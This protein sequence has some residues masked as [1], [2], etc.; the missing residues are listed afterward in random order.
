MAT[1]QLIDKSIVFNP[2]CGTVTILQDR[3]FTDDQGN[4]LAKR[5]NIANSLTKGQLDK[6]DRFAK[7]KPLVIQFWELL[8]AENPQPAN[9][10]FKITKYTKN[11]GILG[12]LNGNGSTYIYADFASGEL[13]NGDSVTITGS[14]EPG[15]NET[16]IIDKTHSGYGR[17][18]IP[19]KF[20]SNPANKGSFT[21]N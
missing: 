9:K 5:P 12:N 19:V 3:I 8:A 6:L 15:Y 16:F 10:I 18:A 7:Y 14:D 4:I 17:F 21:I 2:A 20:L 13:N 11:G 1:E